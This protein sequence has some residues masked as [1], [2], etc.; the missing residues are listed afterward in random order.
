M[1]SNL[2]KKFNIY[3]YN[4]YKTKLYHIFNWCICRLSNN[5]P[6][7]FIM[8]VYELWLCAP[9]WLRWSGW[10][11]RNLCPILNVVRTCHR[12]LIND[13]DALF[14]G[15][16]NKN[17]LNATIDLLSYMPMPFL[18]DLV[19]NGW[20]SLARNNKRPVRLS[21]ALWIGRANESMI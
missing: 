15:I 14:R 19:G 5:V 21:W 17:C 13:C 20:L 2:K 7:F 4:L 10:G 6:W 18:L 11:S 12:C 8:V 16:V 1:F 9:A 3:A